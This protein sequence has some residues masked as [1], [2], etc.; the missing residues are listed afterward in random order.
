MFEKETSRQWNLHVGEDRHIILIKLNMHFSDLKNIY[1]L[2]RSPLA[3]AGWRN[4]QVLHI[5]L[6]KSDG[7]AFSLFDAHCFSN[8]VLWWKW[9]SWCLLL[10]IRRQNME[11]FRIT[12]LTST[13]K[14]SEDPLREENVFCLDSDSRMLSYLSLFSALLVSTQLN[15]V[16]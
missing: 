2:S 5:W 1:D 7:N 6:W 15:V 12:L 4:K 16:L 8:Q 9:T 3:S 10:L 14:R 11:I 13:Y